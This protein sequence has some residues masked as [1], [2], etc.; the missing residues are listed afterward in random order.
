MRKISNFI[1]ILIL[2]ISQTALSQSRNC[3]S[4]KTI[5]LSTC[6]MDDIT[7]AFRDRSKFIKLNAINNSIIKK[8]SIDIKNYK[9]IVKNDSII[10]NNLKKNNLTRDSIIT[11][12]KSEIKSEQKKTAFYKTTTTVSSGI[13]LILLILTLLK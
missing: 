2:L 9:T 12:Q 4:L 3:D 11:V 13:A 1:V 8:D 5:K 6:D 7:T 10:A